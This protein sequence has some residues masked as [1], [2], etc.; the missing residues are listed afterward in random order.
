MSLA[1]QLKIQKAENEHK[2]IVYKTLLHSVVRYTEQTGRTYWLLTYQ[3]ALI[4]LFT[5]LKEMYVTSRSVFIRP[6]GSF[7]SK[8]THALHKH[9]VC[10]HIICDQLETADKS[11]HIQ[12]DT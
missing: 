10:V 7:I 5:T 4:C 9:F 8:V 12:P 1:I 3:C 2:L 11:E 6:G